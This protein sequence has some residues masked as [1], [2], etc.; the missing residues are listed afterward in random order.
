MFKLS[1]TP[2]NT[3][4]YKDPADSTGSLW[5]LHTRRERQEDIQGREP[6][7]KFQCVSL[8]FSSLVANTG[9]S[10]FSDTGHETTIITSWLQQCT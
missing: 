2:T 7:G 1:K 5:P 4:L 9:R 3:I 6:E 8:P 10:L